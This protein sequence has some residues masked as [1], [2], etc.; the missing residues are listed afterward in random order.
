[1][2]RSCFITPPQNIFQLITFEVLFV[3]L[4]NLRLDCFVSHNCYLNLWSILRIVRDCT[5][6]ANQVIPCTYNTFAQFRHFKYF[7]SG[8]DKLQ[9]CFRNKITTSC[10]LVN[11]VCHA[12][13]NWRRSR[14]TML[15]KSINT[16]DE[17]NRN[18]LLRS[19]HTMNVNY[20]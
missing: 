3:E 9:Q 16:V 7:F 13:Q 15:A 17:F 10:S 8:F 4:T 11:A 5:Y 20:C 14:R 18:D 19:N 12:K 2:N 6:Y 1:M